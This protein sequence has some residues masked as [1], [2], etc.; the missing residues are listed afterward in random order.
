MML[1][2]MMIIMM[3]IKSFINQFIDGKFKFPLLLLAF[4][5]LQL[6]LFRP[7][8]LFFNKHNQDIKITIKEQ[9]LSLLL[10]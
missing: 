10:P 6:L 1:I 2:M 4:A 3:I 5:H 8:L 9:F 7:H